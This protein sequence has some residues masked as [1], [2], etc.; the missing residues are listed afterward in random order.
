LRGGSEINNTSR[1]GLTRNDVLHSLRNA[2]MV[3]YDIIST[4]CGSFLH[5]LYKIDN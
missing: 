1:Y 2:V 5:K 4:R 3:V